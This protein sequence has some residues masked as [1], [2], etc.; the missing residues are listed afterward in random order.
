M[1][2][3]M[4]AAIG[5]LEVFL[6]AIIVAL[7]ITIA[8]VPLG[9]QVLATVLV[10]PIIVLT[11]VFIYYCGKRKAWSFAG[12]SILGAIGVL[13]RVAI[14]TQPNLEVGG[15]LPVGVTVLYIVLGAMVSLKN[16]ESVL[17][18]RGSPSSQ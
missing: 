14:S 7:G 18:L 16:Y 5:L 6:A 3:N 13:L 10:S 15:G 1:S 2:I 8:S 12:A 4:R 9:V 17:E 11:I